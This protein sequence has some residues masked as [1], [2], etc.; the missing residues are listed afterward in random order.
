MGILK[1]P[2][3]RDSVAI[4]ETICKTYLIPFTCHSRLLVY[5]I[6]ELLWF[7]T[8]AQMWVWY[9][10]SLKN[11]IMNNWDQI[12]PAKILQKDGKKKK[13]QAF[14]RKATCRLTICLWNELLLNK[15]TLQHFTSEILWGLMSHE[16]STFLFFLK[17]RNVYSARM[18]SIDQKWQ[19]EWQKVTKNIYT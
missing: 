4:M 10:C 1:R 9:C 18:L 13:N 6:S 15:L 3:W 12:W 5:W 14:C 2:G 7:S 16:I 11:I 19:R 17:E 8:E